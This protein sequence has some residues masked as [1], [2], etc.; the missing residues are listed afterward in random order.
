MSELNKQ[1]ALAAGKGLAVWIILYV[2]V[3]HL[4]V[5]WK[6]SS[7]SDDGPL[8]L[9]PKELQER[10][11]RY[12]K[13]LHLHANRINALKEFEG[14][15]DKARSKLVFE[16]SLFLDTGHKRNQ[17]PVTIPKLEKLLSNLENLK[18]YRT[19]GWVR[20][21]FFS[22]SSQME[23]RVEAMTVEEWKL[24]QEFFDDFTLP[25]LDFCPSKMSA[26]NID[27]A[28]ERV[29]EA[30][31][32]RYDDERDVQWPVS[33]PATATRLDAA[34][35]NTLV[36]L[37]EAVGQELKRLESNET[38]S[39]SETENCASQ[40]QILRWL[41][42]GLE[43]CHRKQNLRETMFAT[44]RS[45]KINTTGIILDASLETFGPPKFE[46]KPNLAHMLDTP[47][48]KQIGN[49]IDEK[50]DQWSGYSDWFDAWVDGFGN[51]PVGHVLVSKFLQSA[52]KWPVP[53]VLRENKAGVLKA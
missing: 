17:R 27:E 23:S 44:L 53:K 4:F 31:D 5:F 45:E 33:L 34:W 50:V 14:H 15:V 42:A 49:W 26:P 18:S 46:Y 30:I 24:L 35:S 28:V 43:G 22:A 29:R 9:T 1:I 25:T 32:L 2:S 7:S 8:T 13:F 39:S 20:Q 48:L 47:L 10:V 38:S 12:K 40:A 3:L 11:E 37:R 6:W 36:L 51:D 19:S 52:A 16:E 41:E 21:E